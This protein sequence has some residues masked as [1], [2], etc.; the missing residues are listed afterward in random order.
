MYSFSTYVVGRRFQQPPAQCTDGDVVSIAHEANNPRDRCGSDIVKVARRLLPTC[1]FVILKLV[2]SNLAC[3]D[4]ACPDSL[5]SV[6]P[7]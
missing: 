2:A 6:Y 5:S 1:H 4:I 7:F 3:H